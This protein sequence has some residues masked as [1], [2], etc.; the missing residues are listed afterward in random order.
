[1]QNTMQQHHSGAFRTEAKHSE[2]ENQREILFPSHFIVRLCASRSRTKLTQCSSGTRT[3][4]ARSPRTSFQT[5]QFAS[6]FT[7]AQSTS[8]H[9]IRIHAAQANVIN[10]KP[11]G[12][13]SIAL[14]INAKLTMLF[15]LGWQSD[16]TLQ[17]IDL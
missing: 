15:V 14:S 1:M 9:C 4:A 6:H 2:A 8:A 3:R 16:L 17:M 10:I 5:N 7:G 12:S 13:I 11:R